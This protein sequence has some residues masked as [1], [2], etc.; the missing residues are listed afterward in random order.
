MPS[1][2]SPS[3]SSFRLTLIAISVAALIA[4]CGGGS[5][6]GTA[7]GSSAASGASAEGSSSGSSGSS[8]Q[9]GSSGSDATKPGRIRR[10][11]RTLLDIERERARERDVPAPIDRGDGP[12]PKATE[13]QTGSAAGPGSL[14]QWS[15]ASSWPINAIHAILTPDGKI[16]SYGTDPAGNQGAQLYYDVWNPAT[17]A[18]SLLQHSTRT[19]LFCNA[20]V[21]LPTTGQV[22]LAGGDTRGL[23]DG[24][25][26]NLGVRDT[27][28]FDPVLLELK[29]SG[30]PM[31]YARWYGSLFP[32][33]DGR[34]LTAAGID[35]TAAGAGPPELYTPG[36]GW[37][38]LSKIVDWPADWY[39]PRGFLAP[40][41]KVVIASGSSLYS[42]DVE[43]ETMNT[44]GTLPK[45]TDW[46]LPWA[47]FDRGRMMMVDD[48]G[49]AMVIDVNGATPVITPIAGPGT[50]RVWGT[51]TVLAD[52]KVA[53]TGG[54][55]EDNVLVDTAFSTLI[56]DP[57]TNGWTTGASAAKPRLYHSSAILLPDATVLSVGGG[58]PG[59]VVNLNAEIYSPPYLFDSNGQKQARPLINSAPAKVDLGAT[60]GI[61]V[62]SGRAVQRVTLVR[63]GSVTHSTNFE[64]RFLELPFTQAAGS[65][66]VSITLNEG[67]NTVPIGYYM[68]FVIDSAGVPSVAKIMKVDAG[69]SKAVEQGRSFT[70]PTAT[71]VRYGADSRWVQKTVTGSVACSNEFFGANP[72]P[73][74]A[75]TCEVLTPQLAGVVPGNQPASG[76]KLV[77]NEGGSF[78]MPS[79]TLVSFGADTR[80]TSKTVSGSASC[81]SAFFGL[82][83]APMTAKSCFASAA[84]AP[85]PGT[86]LAPEGGS[87]TV[88]SPTLVRYGADTRWI[89]RTVTGTVS[90]TNTYFGSD[91]APFTVKSCVAG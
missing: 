53:V 7:S 16:M 62:A 44:I 73:G 28:L 90:C 22:L 43:A 6:G 11:V 29:A 13:L 69:W 5:G 14:G 49:G 46:T 58:S 31:Q 78:S 20:Q 17:N 39:Y 27:N 75:K 1:Q 70:L 32:L 12:R 84:P 30:T 57:K 87:F 47:H 50:N 65:S 15:S 25:P 2:R 61:T 81:T 82:D 77:A 23:N 35:G 72:A 67:P 76:D 59:P 9:A 66:N 63:T 83:P 89:S 45:H 33:A 55:S 21:M 85:A 79:A 34:V 10:T 48:E 18:H 91:P 36:S 3:S 37:R 60:F 8:G 64:Q 80:W 88:S 86:V 41:G 4:G 71:A 52:G 74:L 24:T 38:T 40:N 54:S 26:V 56:W 68:L 19:D 51:A 42:L